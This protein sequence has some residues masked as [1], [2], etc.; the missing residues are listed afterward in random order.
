MWPMKILLVKTK[1]EIVTAHKKKK[2]TA[3][4]FIYLIIIFSSV[5]SEKHSK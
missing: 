4:T 2:E 5:Q 1:A 3:D